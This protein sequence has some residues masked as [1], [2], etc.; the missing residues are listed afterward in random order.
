MRA[1][2]DEHSYLSKGTDTIDRALVSRLDQRQPDTEPPF[3]RDEAWLHR[4]QDRPANS[5]IWRWPTV[6]I[7][8]GALLAL[9]W[10]RRDH[11]L[12]DVA[13]PNGARLV[14][15]SC[16]FEP[17]AGRDADCAWFFTADRSHEIPVV[18]LRD[19]S[20]SAHRDDPILF[21]TGG[22][23]Q[24][25]GVDPASVSY[26]YEWVDQ[27]N[28]HRDFIVFD[29]RGT[30]W[31]KPSPQCLE[32]SVITEEHWTSPA[33]TPGDEIDR[34]HDSLRTCQAQL[35]EDGHD[36]AAYSTHTIAADVIDL[37]SALPGD[38]W[39]LYGVSFG[40]RVVLEVLRRDITN[41]RSVV[42]DSVLP[43][44]ADQILEGPSAAFRAFEKVF[45]YC[46][47]D[48]S[49]A[50]R[51]PALRE[52]FYVSLER[53]RRSPGTVEVTLPGELTPTAVVLD[54]E[55][56]FSLYFGSFMSWEAIATLPSTIEAAA[57][58]DWEALREDVQYTVEGDLDTSFSW[59]VY[60]SA[61]CHDAAPY[62]DREAFLTE[63]SRYRGIGRYF[64]SGWDLDPCRVWESGRVN[65]E[66]YESVTST[67]PALLLAGDL[68]PVTPPSWAQLA[69][70]TLSAGQVFIFP[71]I[72]HDVIGNDSCASQVVAAFLENTSQP[73]TDSCF[74]LLDG[75]I[76]HADTY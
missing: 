3:L 42:L 41:V 73:V 63:A 1:Q 46:A 58:G 25:G 23:G 10:A 65:P 9:L 56:L 8:L 50:A 76:F 40:T 20:G 6:L 16:W 24:P 33:A 66:F 7:L 2:I 18:I 44:Q 13:L 21:V 51:H 60:Y 27:L 70:S 57:T 26:W 32:E 37:I 11:L 67:V 36:L 54:E 22:P 38:R 75:A 17:P 74:E 72:G 49:C 47:T 64:E 30:G 55:N 61:A 48:S 68:D 12:D 31:S 28:W 29:P 34:Y 53:A 59:A 69:A 14:Y 35:R 5:P 62:V 52:S 45:N 19:N 15:Q 71:G 43:P 39:N 4:I